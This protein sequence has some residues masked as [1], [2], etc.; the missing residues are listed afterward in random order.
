ME[1]PYDFIAKKRDGGE[2][3][4]DA[5]TGFIHGYTRGDIPDY[6][7]SAWLMACY[8]N[9]LN[10][11]ET[12]ALT[13]VMISSGHVMDLDGI[14]G[15]KV[16]KHSTGGV[17]DKVSLVL[18]PA[19][20]ACGVPVP[21]MSG[22]GL[23]FTGGT[24]DKLQSIP[25]FNVNLTEKE[26]ISILRDVGYV[27]SGQT[28]KL[29]PADRLLYGLRDVTATV[30]NIPLITSSIL[31]KKFAEGADVVVMD[32]KTG[33]G[34]FMKKRE[35]GV[36]LAESI[37]RVAGR[38][39]KVA[40]CVLSNMDQ[41]LGRAIGNSN[42]V[43]ESIACLRGEGPGDVVELVTVLGAQ[44]LVSGGAAENEEAGAH[45]IK[46]KLAGGGAFEKFLSSIERQGGDVDSILHTD[47]LPGAR[48]SQDF[49]ASKSGFIQSFNTESVGTASVLLGAGRLRK[50]DHVDFGSGIYMQRKTGDRVHAGDTIAVLSC[51]DDTNME[52]ALRIMEQATTIGPDQPPP[53]KLVL[54]VIA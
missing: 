46:A 41:P 5:I 29:A 50:E 35:E 32:V 20:A 3:T 18:A 4:K 33:S 37:V 22:R 13:E 14:P 8:L 7:V 43:I 45:M 30:E 1:R 11:E 27:M 15:I 49:K 6:Q 34:A 2:H 16:D 48:S 51:N 25:G 9:G 47:R 40:V 52:Q 19:V 21:M 23:G 10:E 38:L 42:E 54:E 24:L 44:M 12:G 36:R 17:G 39:G 53:F 31:S 26:F 28:D